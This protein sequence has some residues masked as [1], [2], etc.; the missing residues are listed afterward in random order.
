MICSKS[1]FTPKISVTAQDTIV[2]LS[3]CTYDYEDARYV[4]HCKLVPMQ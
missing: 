2:T 3:T 4:L 1:N